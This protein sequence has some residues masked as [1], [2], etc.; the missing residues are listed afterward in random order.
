MKNEKWNFK[1]INDYWLNKHHSSF[2]TLT[3]EAFY[4]P[5]WPQP[6]TDQLGSLWL[7]LSNKDVFVVASSGHW[8]MT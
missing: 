3:S 5:I 2:V 8:E 7:V 6:F 1:Q 4:P